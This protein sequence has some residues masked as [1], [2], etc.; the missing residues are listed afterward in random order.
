MCKALFDAIRDDLGSLKEKQKINNAEQLNEEV[1]KKFNCTSY[2]MYFT[3]NLRSPYVMIHLNP[4]FPR[5]ETPAYARLL[6]SEIDFCEY[7]DFHMNFGTRVYGIRPPITEGKKFDKKQMDFMESLS[8]KNLE[9]STKS[10]EDEFKKLEK[11][12]N[13]KLQL[14]LIPYGSNDFDSGEILKISSLKKHITRVMDT[15]FECERKL[16][17]FC[18]GIFVSIFEGK[19][20]DEKYE[21]TMFHKE[22]FTCTKRDG[23]PTSFK[24]GFFSLE[25]KNKNTQKTQKCYIA[26][27]F[28]KRGISVIKYGKKCQ[29]I[30]NEEKIRANRLINK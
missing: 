30:M 9:T 28:S 3:G 10:R 17:V 20:Y 11:F 4:K 15:I 18:G 27:T 24:L 8:G 21:V 5:G 19:K 16:V 29:E 26:P 12:M 2:P 14:E 1:T 13:E 22:L 23:K 6:P 7:I 25:I